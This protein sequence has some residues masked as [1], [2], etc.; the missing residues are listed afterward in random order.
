M[1]TRRDFIKQGSILSLI[2][3]FIKPHGLLTPSVS[4]PLGTLKPMGRILE[5]EGY[6]VWCCS[7]IDAPDGTTHIF[8]SRW[9]AKKGMAGWTHGSEIAHAVANNPEAPYNV[10]GTVLAPRSGFWDSSTCHNP[11]IH[12]VGNTYCLF[13]MGAG[14]SNLNTQRIGL[15]TASSLYGPWKR[16]DVPILEAGEK[17]AW[18]DECTTNPTF[19][20]HTNGQY[21]LYYISFN[22][23]EY[24]AAAKGTIRGNR[25]CGL[26]IANKIEGPY[27]KYGRN[28]VIDFSGMGN[29]QQLEDP[30]VWKEKGLYKMI[31]RDMGIYS[32]RD[33][34]YMES[35]DG[36]HWSKP[37]KAY[38]ELSTYLSLPKGDKNLKKYGRLER[39]NLLIR[40][41]KPAYLIGA[42][43]GGQYNTSS[44]F[45]FKIS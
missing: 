40:N 23:A 5:Q 38:D 32:Q 45:V 39:P 17:G 33:G 1:T 15:A 34:L 11:S 26:A 19:L 24:N 16:S 35:K 7:P 36:V 25:K 3:A 42:T 9:D 20:Q 13:Y 41:G 22:E 44:G 4:S 6:F 14:N 28:P 18:D 8:F 43:Q 31:S 2:G 27:E 30:F 10:I 12:K 21:W 37:V 29:N